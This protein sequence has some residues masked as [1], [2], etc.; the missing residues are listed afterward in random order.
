MTTEICVV[1]VTY[2]E[3]PALLKQVV[4]AVISESVEHVIVVSNGASWDVA[5]WAYSEMPGKVEV[6][7]LPSN[8]G[9][10]PAFS[11]GI[12]K[13]I[14]RGAEFVWLLDDDNQ[15]E[16]G[17]LTNLLNAYERLR[18]ESPRERL[19]VAAFRPRRSRGVL[20]DVPLNRNIQRPSTFLGFHVVSLPVMLWRHSRWGRPCPRKVIPP[21]VDVD[22]APY[23]GLLF[24][25]SL[26]AAHGLPRADFVLYADDWE[27][28]SRITRAG[29]AIRI[30]T[31]ARLRELEGA[32]HGRTRVLSPFARWLTCEDWRAFYG[33]RNHVYVDTHCMPHSRTMLF[34]N[35]CFCY[36]V[37][38]VHALVYPRPGRFSLLRRAIRNGVAGKLGLE[39]GIHL[40]G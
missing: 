23:G 35:R 36:L 5:G 28:T 34:I 20:V 4:G 19:A 13:A 37:L 25:R 22:V 11:V 2:K 30:V 1:I 12:E 9:S 29:G 33:V 31:A 14:E 10:A 18:A 16:P 7:A 24:H 38:W 15:P 40:G 39:E 8:S 3:R 26:I 21:F 17:A 32:W 27:F 6:V